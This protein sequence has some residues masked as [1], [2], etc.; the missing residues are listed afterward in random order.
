M[1]EPVSP[2]VNSLNAPFWQ[3]ASEG[4]LVMPICVASER[5]FW[6]PSSLSPFVSGGKVTWREVAPLG[7]LRAMAIYRRG[8]QKAFSAQLPY[9]V[10]L[11][12][13]DAGPRLHVHL[14]GAASAP[15][16]GARVKISF[17]ILVEGGPRVPTARAAHNGE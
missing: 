16:A 6:P 17:E 3:G 4:R 13:L 11:V 8:F 2:I 7:T 14:F 9:A 12:E 1:T 15:A 5:A 10:G